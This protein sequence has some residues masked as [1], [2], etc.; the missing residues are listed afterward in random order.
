MGGKMTRRNKHMP[1]IYEIRLENARRLQADMKQSDFAEKIR[2][3][4]TQVSRFMGKNPT[5][6]IGD[7]MARHIEECFGLATTWLDMQHYTVQ[8]AVAEPIKSYAVSRTVCIPVFDAA[9]AAGS[10]AYIDM[11]AASEYFELDQSI[12][13]SAGLNTDRVIGARVHGNSMTPRLLD[14]DMILIDTSDRRPRDGQVYAIAVENELQVKRI[15]RP[16]A[17]NH[18]IITTDNKDDPAHRDETISA[19][20]FE[21]LRVIGRVVMILMGGL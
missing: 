17:G 3:A 21:Q 8:H 1:D 10:G 4:Q 7:D 9:M 14:G 11:D 2:R 18:Y 16:A 6:R 12:I 13:E 15:L 20:N 5:K 19:Q